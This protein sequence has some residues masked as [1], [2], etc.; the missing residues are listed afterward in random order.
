MKETMAT[1]NNLSAFLFG[2]V[3]PL[4]AFILPAMAVPPQNP[5][6]VREI[7][8]M[9]P[10]EPG[11]PEARI[12]NRELWDFCRDRDG[13]ASY[14]LKAAERAMEG[15]VVPPDDSLYEQVYAWNRASTKVSRRL[16]CLTLGECLENKGRFLPKIIECLEV[17]SAQ[18]T[19][20][21]PYHDRPKFGMFKGLYSTTDLEIAEQTQGV[22]VTLDQ[23]R[24]RLPPDVVAR[25]ERA[26]WKNCFSNY[27]AKA[28]KPA[29]GVN[30]WFF[31]DNN[32]NVAC[33]GWCVAAALRAIPDRETRAKF[34]EAAERGYP[35]YLNGF[36][37]D[38][39]CLEGMDYWNFGFGMFMHL[40]WTVRAATGGRVDFFSHPMARTDF[41]Y[42]YESQLRMG[43]APRFGDG[44]ASRP[45]AYLLVFGSRIWPEFSTSLGPKVGMRFAHM[46]SIP[47]YGINFVGRKVMSSGRDCTLPIR[48]WFPDAQTLVCR[49][50][51]ESSR[52][53]SVCIHG[54]H[55]GNP[56]N[57]NDIGQYI[58]AVG[59]S[60]M[61]E[62][63]AGAVYTLDT[64]SSKRYDSP[65]LNSYSHAVPR[66]DGTLQSPGRKFA[67]K[68]MGHGFSDD[69]DW[70]ELDLAGAYNLTN[71]AKL[72]KLVRRFEY[73]R[74]DGRVTVEDSVAF[75]VPA[76]FETAVSTYGRIQ[77][78]P[79]PGTFAIVRTSGSNEVRLAF[80][81]DAHGAKW[82]VKEEKIPNPKRTEPT[83]WAVVLD[84]PVKDAKVTLRYWVEAGQ[85]IRQDASKST[86]VLAK[87][88][89]ERY[90]REIC[91]T[92]PKGA[93]FAIDPML[94]STHDEYS[95]RFRGGEASFAGANG[96]ALL[97]AVYDFLSRRCGCRW[98]W[99]GDFVPKAGRI[100][101][102]GPDIREKSRFEHRAIR[103][104]AHRGL[105]RFQAEHWG[106]ED[107]KRE[108]DWCV[109]N[110]INTFMLRIGQDDLFQKAFPDVCPYPDPS[111]P[112]PESK[113]LGGGYNDRSL[114]WP[115]EFRGELRKQVLAYAFER[116]LMAP[117]DFGTMSH[118]YSRTPHTFIDKMKPTFLPQQGGYYGHPTDRVWDIRERR[119]L[120]AYWKLTQAAIDNYG[121]SGLLH[122]IG[123]AERHC[124][125][126]RA[127]NLRMKV[128]MLNLMVSNALSHYPESKILLAGWDFYNGWRPNE[129][130]SLLATLDPRKVLLWDYEA[131]AHDK[132]NF[133]EWGVVGK[134]PYTFGIFLT[135]A[136][137]LDV[138]ADYARIVSRQKLVKDDPMCRGYLFWPESSHTDQLVINY[139]VANC[140]NADRPDVDAIVDDLSRGRYGDQAAA[141][142]KI[143]R[144]VIPVSTNCCDTWRDNCGRA[145][146]R[147]CWNPKAMEGLSF[148]S[149]SPDT[150]KTVP[151]IFRALAEI[152]WEGAF[153]RRD[154]IDLARTAADRLLLSLMG[155]PKRNAPKV[156]RLMRPFADLLALHTDYSLAE[157]YDRLNAVKEIA[158]PDFDRTL[159]GNAVNGYCASH[160]YEAFAHVHLPWWDALAQTG[161]APARPMPMRRLAEMR[162]TLPR[163][164]ENY[165][166]TL[167]DLAAASEE[168]FQ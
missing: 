166:R 50:A 44:D 38:G 154:A 37:H 84:E 109:K 101:L 36:S 143:W 121:K 125:T 148:R 129:V 135:L 85:P 19:W 9:L 89:F 134:F 35:Y 168:V 139:F 152:R 76:A 8:A 71:A 127:D 95:V 147:L 12:G 115:L 6:R 107:W 62:D 122:T 14:H 66:I 138:R 5:D 68:I 39:Y 75:S 54:G 114:F 34:I 164:A 10:E 159:W 158:Y 15:P 136:Q 81:V 93:T 118:W 141:F 83:R 31:G 27:L 165:R 130:Q 163:T 92:V 46:A 133:T 72:T 60:Q 108:I 149:V 103:Y 64:F 123:I 33:H 86:A 67:A 61:V 124:Y 80:S 156:A 7:V 26:L 23:L 106:L 51:A 73:A 113:G 105:T 53:L 100:D 70:L 145:S 1:K 40:G 87:D 97:Y 150:L 74:T 43:V 120:D 58:I 41:A 16:A 52:S 4:S 140:W 79:T 162:P 90:C 45:S 98:Y 28:E 63:P 96:R 29:L 137:G 42:A 91:G 13:G 32:W 57:H 111:K 25:A 17:K 69:R 155:E 116:G 110:R 144:Q 104:F 112:S 24:G 78:G 160:H 142:A 65:M 146:L 3:L 11:F 131:D 56:H 30:R 126:N 20:M 117:E 102:S 99:D 94:D 167:L 153:A 132:T 82:H 2:A 128:D 21:N 22:A 49:P 77:P 48:S 47:Y 161:A 18:T 157:S 55:N 88:V 59:D 119:W 151:G